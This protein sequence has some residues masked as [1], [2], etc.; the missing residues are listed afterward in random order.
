MSAALP[1]TD[2]NVTADCGAPLLAIDLL[3]KDAAGNVL[4]G[5]RGD[6]PAHHRWCVPGGRVYV[7]ETLDQAFARL[8]QDEAG[9]PPCPRSSA[10]FLGVYE[11]SYAEHVL[12][13]TDF[14]SYCVVLTYTLT[15]DRQQLP[16]PE[17]Q[18]QAYRWFNLQEALNDVQVGG[19]TRVYLEALSHPKPASS[20][21]AAPLFDAI[22]AQWNEAQP[23]VAKPVKVSPTESRIASNWT[24]CFSLTLLL[25]LL[26]ALFVGGTHPQAGSLFAPPWD[27]AA[28][29]SMY[30]SLYLLFRESFTAPSWLLAL[31]VVLIGG[32]DEI[33]QLSLP[34]RQSDW[35]DFA[36]DVFGVLLG[37]VFRRALLLK[38]L[39]A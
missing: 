15:V 31:I 3:V 39:T 7:N 10:E 28:H 5:F 37:I 24:R 17:N 4:L 12:N 19:C 38:K 29:A 20:H 16:I 22:H 6:L 11:H 13:H 18:E 35:G 30:F 21:A 33:H 36:A 25:A 9:L 2:A 8:C 32:V 34:H 14:D 27:K 1:A 23:L 26:T